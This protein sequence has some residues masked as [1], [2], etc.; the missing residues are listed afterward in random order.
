MKTKD[1]NKNLK[2]QKKQSKSKSK[3]KINSL[4]KERSNK[5]LEIIENMDSVNQMIKNQIKIL[6]LN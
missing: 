4:E 5:T 6:K 2:K 3:N 1:K